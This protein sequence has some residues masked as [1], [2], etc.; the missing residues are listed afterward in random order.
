[1]D[2][3]AY[4]SIKEIF[5]LSLL[6][7]AAVILGFLSGSLWLFAAAVSVLAIKMFPILLV[8]IALAGGAVLAVRYYFNK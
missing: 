1:V 5:M 3:C 7:V 4:F 6:L 8:V 2:F